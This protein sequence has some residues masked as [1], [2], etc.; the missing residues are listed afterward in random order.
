MSP[1]W[2]HLLA[3]GREGVQDDGLELR[4]AAQV[5]VMADLAQGEQRQQPNGVRGAAVLHVL[6]SK[7][8]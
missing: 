2:R 1:V 8:A 7:K 3:G 6:A 4:L 5:H